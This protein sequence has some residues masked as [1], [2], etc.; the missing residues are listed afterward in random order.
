MTEILTNKQAKNRKITVKSDKKMFLV[1]L[2]WIN[3]GCYIAM[4]ITTDIKIEK[5]GVHNW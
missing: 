2:T 1:A 3:Q 4:L 5:P